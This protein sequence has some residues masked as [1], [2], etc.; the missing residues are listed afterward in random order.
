MFDYLTG[1]MK[2]RMGEERGGENGE[3]RLGW[4]W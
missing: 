3:G 4:N 2:S 1:R